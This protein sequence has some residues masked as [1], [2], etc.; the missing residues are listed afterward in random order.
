MKKETL[1]PE[2]ENK[3]A[4]RYNLY[5]IEYMYE[6]IVEKLKERYPMENNPYMKIAFRKEEKNYLYRMFNTNRTDFSKY[7][8]DDENTKSVT[9]KMRST[10]A[11][12]PDLETFITGER[13]II[14]N[15]GE[16]E[17]LNERDL[18]LSEKTENGLR[19]AVDSA[20]KKVRDNLSMDI[21]M[22]EGV[23][24]QLAGWMIVK[25]SEEYLK[26]K[27]Q[28]EQIDNIVLREFEHIE[29]ISFEMLDECDIKTVEVLQKK[30]KELYA[31]VKTVYQYKNL[32]NNKK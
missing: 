13:Y 17:Y 23:I 6:Y 9:K 4:F 16:E 25:I 31:V 7:K 29:K 22:N 12:Y 28:E 14:D 2:I 11:D 3:L 24:V 5:M 32:K 30:V 19:T 1:A 21:L 8:H 15:K 20:W 27:K 26:L 10:F 18:Q